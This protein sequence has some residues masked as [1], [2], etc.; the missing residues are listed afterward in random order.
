MPSTWSPIRPPGSPRRSRRRCSRRAPDR[1]QPA[2]PTTDAFG[3]GGDDE[4]VSA[5]DALF[6]ES[7]FREYTEGLDPSQNPFV[8]QAEAAANGGAVPAIR[9]ARSFRQARL[10]RSRGC[11][12]SC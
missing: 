10:R 3:L 6:G 7:Q 4:Q 2:A 9:P 11:S 12:A 8:R 5:I 1:E